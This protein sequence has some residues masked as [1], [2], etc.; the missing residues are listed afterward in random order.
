MSISPLFLQVRWPEFLKPP[1]GYSDGKGLPKLPANFEDLDAD[2]K[3]IALFE[4]ERA[5]YAKAYEVAT[6]LNNHDAYTAKWE[7]FEPLRELFLRCGNT[8]EDDPCPIHFT[9]ADIT[10]Y[11]RQLS[12][13][14]QWH[15]IQEFAKKYLD[16]DDEGW[17]SPEVDWAEKQSQNM[18][19]L[20]LMAAR[21][22][23]Q[24]SA[25][26]VRRIWPFPT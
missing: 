2:E 16:T 26:E 4:K 7:F 8:W 5:T 9:A 3:E 10:S 1:E 18:A 20:E 22:E 12:E 15:E 6:Y 11:E 19:L 17:V 23:T 13:Y 24:K 25:D 14:T 21:L